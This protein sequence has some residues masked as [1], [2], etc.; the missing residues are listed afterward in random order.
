ML[1]ES[2]N[3]TQTSADLSSRPFFLYFIINHVPVL[4]G[5]WSRS[6]LSYILKTVKKLN[7][8]NL[9]VKTGQQRFCPSAKIL[10]QIK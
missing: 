2:L 10:A 9:E 1:S 5:F 8:E 4:I 7:I 6:M 3:S